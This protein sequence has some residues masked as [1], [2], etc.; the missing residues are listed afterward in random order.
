MTALR[1][2]CLCGGVKFEV[3]EAPETLR[4]CHCAS[5]KKLSGGTGTLNGRV[6]STSIR[7]LEGA[8]LLE[9]FE[10][11]GEARRR[12]ARG[13]ARISS[14]AAGPTRRSRV[15]ERVR[16]T[17]SSPR[18]RARTSTS[19]PSLPGKRCRTTVSSA[20]RRR[21]AF[22]ALI[23]ERLLAR[24]RPLPVQRRSQPRSPDR[25]AEPRAPARTARA[26]GDGRRR[27]STPNPG[28]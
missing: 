26:P 4:Y 6:R 13:A 16:W 9:T 25:G 22:R 18:A 3:S 20:S 21:P 5:C 7:I 11:P 27:R 2:S 15:C 28:C 23:G 24:F 12:S 19:D 17:T 1:G 10:P 14:A 8:D